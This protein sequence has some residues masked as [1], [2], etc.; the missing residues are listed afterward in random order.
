M[1]IITFP[2]H[3]SFSLILTLYLKACVFKKE[4]PEWVC[5]GLAVSMWFLD[6]MQTRFHSTGPGD[7]ERCLLQ[8]GT[9]KQRKDLGEKQQQERAWEGLLWLTEK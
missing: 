4:T 7:F 9:V 2:L 3:D 1:N 6:I 5:L 8:L